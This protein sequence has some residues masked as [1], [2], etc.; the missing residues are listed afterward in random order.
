MSR[1]STSRSRVVCFCSLMAVALLA[2]ACAHPPTT[3]S[4][5]V[6]DIRIIEG[7]DPADLI[8]NAGDE[9][10]WVNARSLPLRVDLVGVKHED[11]SCERGFSN[12]VGTVQ[13]TATVK[14]NESASACFTKAGVINYNLRM[15]SPLPGGEKIASGV[16]RVGTMGR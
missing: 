6:H 12:I 1:A 16:V 15:E 2:S 14:P 11:L 13:E 8:I 9:V 4:G 7:P 5:A 3:R 10:R